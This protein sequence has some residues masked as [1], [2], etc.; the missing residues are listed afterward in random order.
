MK[1]YS[2][3]LFC[4]SPPV[5]MVTFLFEILG[6]IYSTLRYKLNRVGRLVVAVLLFLS[7]FQLAEYMICEVTGI[8]GLT[9]AK[10]GYISIT[11]LPPLGISLAMA[12]AGK[13]YKSWSVALYLFMFSFI[14]YFLIITS[15]ISTESCLGNYVIFSMQHGVGWL[16]AFYYYGL[17]FVGVGLSLY[18]REYSDDKNTRKSLL[19]LAIGYMTFIIPTTTVNIIN[20]DTI[21]GIPSIM[22]GFAVFLAIILLGW[23]LPYSGTKRKA[24]V[25]S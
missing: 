20:P 3:K 5:M 4:F 13:K 17:L 11:A 6:A 9:W 25:L 22:C 19:A 7:I 23:I 1:K 21:S 24:P 12:I 2:D 10:I 16:Y 18:W 15:A 14:A 8:P